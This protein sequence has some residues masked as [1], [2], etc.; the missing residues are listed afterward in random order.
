PFR[1]S[2]G[3][4]YWDKQL[5]Q[6]Q[7]IIAELT[8]TPPVLLRA[9]G[10]FKTRDLASAAR[11]LQLSFVGWS[12]RAAD[13]ASIP[14]DQLARRVLKRITGFDIVLLHD[15]VAPH[16]PKTLGRQT[17]VDALPQI[18]RGIADK[19]LQAASLIDA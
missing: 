10:G 17:L 14:A 9:P 11:A 6:T 19:K 7:A 3:T 2:H 4:P 1:V 16:A 5:R 18:F 8:G 13:D 15:G 12:V